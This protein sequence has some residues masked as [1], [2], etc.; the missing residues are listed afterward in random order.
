MSAPDTNIS[1][2]KRRHRGPLGGFVVAGVVVS[3]LLIVFLARVLE[4]TPEDGP[5]P[6]TTE[7]TQ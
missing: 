6:A 4:P 5:V 3:A 2:Q 7:I 1:K